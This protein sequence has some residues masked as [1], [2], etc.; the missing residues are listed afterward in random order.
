[1]SDIINPHPG[2]ILLEEFLKPMGIRARLEVMVTVLCGCTCT[3]DVISSCTA[4]TLA[5]I[6]STSNRALRRPL[7]VAHAPAGVVARAR[8]PR[9]DRGSDAPARAWSRPS[10]SWPAKRTLGEIAGA[11]GS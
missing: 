6:P 5:P 8:S 7:G 3:A 10:A 2:E 9:T 1:M 11:G 4:C